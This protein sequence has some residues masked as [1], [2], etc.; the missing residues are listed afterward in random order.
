MG[1]DSISISE[2]VQTNI[3]L[4]CVENEA[5]YV[6]DL[7]GFTEYPSED[8]L[9]EFIFMGVAILKINDQQ[10]RVKCAWAELGYCAIMWGVSFFLVN[11]V[12][13]IVTTVI[14]LLV[15]CLY[16]LCICPKILHRKIV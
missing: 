8:W 11:V 3:T 2:R 12:G 13:N 1:D 15:T 10:H 5:Y 14:C 9:Y 4:C 6:V 7:F 16:I